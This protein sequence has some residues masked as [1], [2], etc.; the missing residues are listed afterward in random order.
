MGSARRMFAMRAQ[1]TFGCEARASLIG[2][3]C[4]FGDRSV[5]GGR[6]PP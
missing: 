4:A 3:E 5:C 1:R 6:P 2:Q